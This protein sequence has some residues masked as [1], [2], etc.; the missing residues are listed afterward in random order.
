MFVHS[1]GTVSTVLRFVFL[2]LC[3]IWHLTDGYGYEF[4]L[5][6]VRSSVVLL[7]LDFPSLGY[8]R[9]LCINK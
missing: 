7:V 4:S 6:V 2:V 1:L 9:K 3:F 5:I 8:E